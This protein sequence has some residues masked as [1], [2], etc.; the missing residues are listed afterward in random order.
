MSLRNT[1]NDMNYLML[2]ACLLDKKI[3]YSNHILGYPF[4]CKSLWLIEYFCH[5]DIDD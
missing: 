3:N 5:R 2:K 4:Y 1:R